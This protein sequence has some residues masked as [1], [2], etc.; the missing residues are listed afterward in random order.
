MNP[1]RTQRS[2]RVAALVL[3]AAMPGAVTAGDPVKPGSLQDFGNPEPARGWISVGFQAVHT[4]GSLDGSGGDSLFLR[5]LETDSRS[6]TLSVDY[7]INQRWSLNASLPYI[8]KRAVNDRG[9]HNPARLAVPR[10][11]SQF[12]DDGDYHGTWQDWQLG[13]TYHAGF[14]GFDVRPHAV[15]T[16]PSRDYTFFASAAAGQR[17]KRVRL[18]F[19]ASRRL[20][21]SNFHYSAGYSYEFVER[22]L[23]NN[24]DK[25]HLRLSGRYDISPQLS[26]NVFA[27]G[28]RGQGLDPAIFLGQSQLGS[29]LWYQHDRLL[30]HNYGLAGLGVTWRFN[31]V[32]SISGSTSRMVWGDSI[33]AIKYAHE[34]QFTRAF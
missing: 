12:L 10:P 18:G 23:G 24:L 21:L 27:V 14:A 5:T 6:L 32:W 16:Y 26:A 22:V 30:P 4:R 2:F 1:K 3:A 7:R 9:F 19:D 8:R 31:D 11:D 20:G 33:H 25:Q 17:L 13:V 28:R 29:E 34:L 15:L